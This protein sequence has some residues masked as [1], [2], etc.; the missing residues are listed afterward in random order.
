MSQ[1][2]GSQVIPLTAPP[3]AE[4]P[5]SPAHNAPLV[6]QLLRSSIDAL[7]D[8]YGISVSPQAVRDG[9]LGR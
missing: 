3:L 6:R 2:A 7:E 9:G 4:L 5:G 1:Q 8:E